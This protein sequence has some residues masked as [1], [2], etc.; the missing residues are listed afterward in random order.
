LGHWGLGVPGVRFGDHFD[1]PDSEDEGEEA[2]ETTEA[3]EA[4]KPKLLVDPDVVEVPDLSQEARFNLT[5]HNISSSH[6]SHTLKIRVIHN[7]RHGSTSAWSQGLYQMYTAIP[8]LEC[9]SKQ[10]PFESFHLWQK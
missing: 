10:V 5:V 1:A 8:V 4:E 2:K 9:L 7:C 3:K 6:D